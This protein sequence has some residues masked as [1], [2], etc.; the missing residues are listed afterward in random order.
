MDCFGPFYAKDGRRELKRYGLLLLLDDL[1]TD[2]F[3]NSLC[4]FIRGNVRQIRRDQGSNSIGARREFVDA[5][6]EMDQTGLKELGCEFIMN[7]LSL[8]HKCLGKTNPHDTK[9]LNIHS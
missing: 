9:C 3:I 7:T 6:K 4:S 1:T 2:A 8:S 5:L